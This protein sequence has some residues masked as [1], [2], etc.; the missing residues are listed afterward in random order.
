MTEQFSLQESAETKPKR[1]SSIMRF[2]G[3]NLLVAILLLAVLV[4]GASLR[5][6]G[7]NWDDFT[8]LHPDERFLTLNL[9][10]AVGGGLEF[11]RDEEHFTTQK[12]LTR[13]GETQFVSTVELANNPSVI[14]GASQGVSSYDAAVWTF[15]DDRVRGFENVNVV[16]EALSRGDVGAIVVENTI[17]EQA[18]T[19]LLGTLFPED[20]QRSYCTHHNPDT[21][22]AGGYFDT[23]C[24]PLNPH[25]AGQGFYTYGTLPLFMAHFTGEFFLAQENA[26]STL[27]N[28]ESGHL[29]WRG[30][31]AVF[32]LGT[33]LLIFLIGTRMHNKWVGLLAALL[34]AAA[35]LAVQKSHFG[36]VNAITHFVVSLALLFALR[37]QDRGRLLDY[38]GFGLACGAAVASRINTAP[39][40]GIIVLVAIVRSAPVIDAK[41]P[42]NERQRLLLTNIVAVLVAGVAAFLAF[43]IF[44]PYAFS[45]PSL[46]GLA[47]NPRWFANI[48]A[49]TYGVSG[50][51]DSPPNWQWMGR[52]SYLFPLKDMLLWGMGI[53]FGVTAWFGWLWSGFCLLRGKVASTRNL[54]LFTWILVYF[55]WMGR[56][57]V[58]T[59][60]YY[61]PLYGAL[62]VLAAWALWE[63]FKLARAGDTR[64]TQVLLLLF[65]LIIGGVALAS[66]ETMQL[67]TGGVALIL[68]LGAVV[69]QLKQSRVVLLTVFVAGF[70]LLWG[71]MFSNIYRHQLTRVQGSRWLF[72][73][74]SG[75]FSMQIEGAPEGTP[76]INLALPNTGFIDPTG[77][78]LLFERATLYNEGAPFFT[79]FVA[80]HDGVIRSIFAPHLGDPND[81]VETEALTIYVS[82]DTVGLPLATATLDA[83]LSREH[84]LL[85]DA[86]ELVFEPPL[87]VNAG[88]TY[89]V[90]IEALSGPIIG[91]GSV[92]LTEG[93]WDDRL[94]TTQ[95]CE[96]PDG[97]TLADD[98]ASG[99][100]SFE[101]CNGRQSWHALVNSYDMSMSYPVDND[102][103]LDSILE[104][105]DVGDYLTISS[106][107]FYDTLSRNQVRWPMST[108]Y[109]DSLFNEELGFEL[110]AVF[111]ES[112]EFGPLHVS[113][114]HLPIYDSPAW[115]NELEADEAFHVYDHPAVFIFKKTPDY[116]S[117]QVRLTLAEIPLIQNNQ[118]LGGY[119]DPSLVGVVYWAS[120]DADL[121]PTALQLPPDKLEVQQNGGT[122]S[123]RFHRDSFINTQ[124]FAGVVIWWALIMVFGWIA[125]PLLFALFPA[126]GDRGYSFA[127]FAGLLL[128]SWLA[129]LVSSANVP[130]WSAGGVLMAMLLVA[131][132]SAFFGIRRR[133]QLLTFLRT[134][135]KRLAVIEVI[136]LALFLLLIL[137]R[138]SNPDLWH[139]AKGGEKPMDFAYFN[140]VL[141]STVFPP[142]DPWYAGGYINY[143]YYGFVIVGAPVLLLGM[144]PS[145]A[146]NL[147]VPTLFALTGIGAFSVAFNLVHAWRG[148]RSDSKTD[149]PRRRMGNPWLAGFMALLLAVFFGN[150][151]TVRVIGNGLAQLGGYEMPRGLQSYL[152]QEYTEE[153][154]VPPPPDIQSEFARARRSRFDCR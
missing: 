112:F 4:F 131:A 7:Q 36:T 77:S 58:M 46:F 86:Y 59:M 137:V 81:D 96:L 142:L 111:Q 12:I 76:I 125:F 29:I 92:I 118:I 61:L 136:T 52:A 31:S 121:A 123:E 44:N 93:D 63:L 56:L 144:V 75:D 98:P 148:R 42:W 68:L 116:T 135:W 47:P 16:V 48:S 10:P 1:A 134:H 67:I 114:Q 149:S 153:N 109:Y 129:W 24:S 90:K 28:F 122:W 57:W 140:A 124:Q 74:A 34:Y 117:E 15:G 27:F 84:H 95:I 2:L 40:A 23:L 102:I 39:L 64:W 50:Y 107:R 146:Y 151:D 9:L 100:V 45:G 25:N 139:P 6:T 14:I 72:E 145:F 43:R 150:L 154:G 30:L 120:I 106:N 32:D 18:G 33:I 127:K 5:L 51:Q 26:G 54:L 53:A 94:T 128:I 66:T 65:S 88:Q 126:M 130:M 115:L 20:L 17:P 55:A 87:Q 78:N 83:N 3:G 35:P 89:Q 60:R 85:G 62:A 103:K 70:T 104:S 97:L 79:D 13:I 73:N 8:Y 11:T 69:P 21:S 119:E 138:L 147:I 19:I 82:L 141:R 99:L 108:R 152:I 132:L 101:E 49:G 22:G 91:S 37:A 80:S 110:A 105:L 143:Y 71:M 38:I 41:L 113:D 133:E